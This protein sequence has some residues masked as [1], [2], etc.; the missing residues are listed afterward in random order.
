MDVR[1]KEA[2]EALCD[3]IRS[4]RAPVQRRRRR[5]GRSD[6]HRGARR[7][8]G[9]S[10]SPATPETLG[11]SAP[12]ASP[13]AASALTPLPLPLPRPHPLAR[14][15]GL[16]GR[17]LA[18]LGGR[19]APLPESSASREAV[20]A[21][22]AQ[23]PRG[24]AFLALEPAVRHVDAGAGVL[25]YR[26]AGRTAFSVGGVL[27]PGGEDA[28]KS[29]LLAFREALAAHGYRRA[30]C[31][32]LAPAEL[33]AAHAAGFDA[34]ETGAEAHLDPR[35]FTLAGREGA[36]LRQMCNR[37]RTRFGLS[38]RET[39]A[40]DADTE[41][42]AFFAGWRA[43]R[44]GARR[45]RLVLGTPAVAEPLGRRYFGVWR[46]GDAEPAAAVT[47][48]PGWSG[49]GWGVDVMARHPD[50]PPGAMDLLLADLAV[51]LGEEGAEHLSLGACPMQVDVGPGPHRALRRVFRY[52]HDSRL[53]NR[54]F[55]FA[56]LSHFKAKF[57]PRWEP[58]YMGIWPRVGVWPLYQGCRMWG[59]FGD[60]ESC[61]TV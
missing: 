46:S 38:L 33:R 55:R 60:D 48:I 36:D 5:P 52:L 20:A 14:A 43:R 9:G 61:F 51:R 41:L 56:G 47:L 2:Y 17:L 13:D 58:V 23:S 29:S 32:P 44:L 35:A 39:P 54:L 34:V 12:P 22:A 27:G 6:A 11:S 16:P 40:S 57:A 30:L 24:N 42:G 7:P 45:L 15:L 31:F 4:G 26:A 50:A 25:G 3:D 59:L 18:H 1:L 28:V 21:L 10:I 49:R 8:R 19:A 53:G 37:A